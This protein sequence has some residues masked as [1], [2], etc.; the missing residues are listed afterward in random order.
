MAPPGLCSSLPYGHRE[1]RGRTAPLAY[2]GLRPLGATA[3]PTPL[4]ALLQC[5]ATPAA[6]RVCGTGPAPIFTRFPGRV[7]SFPTAHLAGAYICTCSNGEQQLLEFS[8]NVFCK[9]STSREKVLA[10]WEIQQICC[11][12]A[13]ACKGNKATQ[14]FTIFICAA[15]CVQTRCFIKEYGLHN[16]IFH[17]SEAHTACTGTGGCGD[18][19]QVS[20][21][22]PKAAQTT[23][24]PVSPHSAGR[25]GARG[26][27]TAHPSGQRPELPTPLPAPGNTRRAAEATPTPLR[28]PPGERDP[29]PC[30][31]LLRE[32][33]DGGA[34]AGTTS[35]GHPW[36]PAPDALV[37]GT[38]SPKQKCSTCTT[39]QDR[40]TPGSGCFC[41]RLPPSGSTFRGTVA[42]PTA[43][44]VPGGHWQPTTTF[45][46][47]DKTSRQEKR[48]A[49]GNWTHNWNLSREAMGSL[50]VLLCHPLT[51][52][53]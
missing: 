4:Q 34:R 39:Q 2:T 23:R 42:A 47:S 48:M 52:C 27:C 6:A 49:L 51:L 13:I 38:R 10:A 19:Q 44:P 25:R 7:E 14:K 26:G 18:C 29:L 28:L 11:N 46:H 43:H 20:T 21:S 35:L 17:Y 40:S 30:G 8:G 50:E 41:Q 16:Y 22:P 37:P 1:H 15:I 3:G 45:S 24:V 33:G 9:A 5:S 53:R 31:Q 36:L 32:P 12:G